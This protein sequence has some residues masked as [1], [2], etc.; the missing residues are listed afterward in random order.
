MRSQTQE[1][2]V[3]KEIAKVYTT[4]MQEKTLILTDLNLRIEFPYRPGTP[5][6]SADCRQHYW[7][8]SDEGEAPKAGSLSLTIYSTLI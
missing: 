6:Y 7:P 8:G 1:E 3:L 2:L 5:L 4:E